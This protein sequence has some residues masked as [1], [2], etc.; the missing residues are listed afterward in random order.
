V[1]TFRRKNIFL[2]SGAAEEVAATITARA[3]F[4]F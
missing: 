1:A 4:F 2:F 3:T